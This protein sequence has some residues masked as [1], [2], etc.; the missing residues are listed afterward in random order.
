MAFHPVSKMEEVLFLSLESPE[1]FFKDTEKA[2]ML[3]DQ[4]KDTMEVKNGESPAGW[5]KE[6]PVHM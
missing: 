5:E 1:Q 4:L 2:K 6:K 3:F